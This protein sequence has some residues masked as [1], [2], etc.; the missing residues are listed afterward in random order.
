MKPTKR[1]VLGTRDFAVPQCPKQ[2]A[3]VDARCDLDAGHETRGD[4]LHAHYGDAASVLLW[5]PAMS[6]P[7]DAVDEGS[8]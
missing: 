7:V 1:A 4:P 5:A 3:F 8:A 6:A 2:N